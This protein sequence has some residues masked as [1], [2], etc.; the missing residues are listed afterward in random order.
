MRFLTVRNCG[1]EKAHTDIIEKF[2]LQA[3][4]EFTP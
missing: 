2:T 1:S 4:Q 3:S